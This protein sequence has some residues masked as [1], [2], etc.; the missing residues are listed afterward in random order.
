MDFRKK[1]A[2]YEKAPLGSPAGLFIVRV[3]SSESDREDHCD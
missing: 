2:R 3:K 1:E